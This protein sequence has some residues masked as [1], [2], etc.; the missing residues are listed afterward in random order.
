[1]MRR[2]FTIVELVIVLTIMG[3]L[4]AVAVVNINASQI[5][6]RDTERKADIEAISMAL[7][8]YYGN[9]DSASSGI[10]DMSG[11]SYPSTASLSSDAAF[12]TAFPDIDQKSVRAPD[13]ELTSPRS[14]VPATNSTASTS[15]VLPQPTINSYVYQP[16]KKDGSLC[17]QILQK[18]D[19]R[20]FNL[21]YRLEI[22]NSVQMVTSRHQS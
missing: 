13:V 3:I 17:T 18:G 16:I 14:I 1:M 20:R 7:E 6:A 15:G 4:L 2:G 9:E 10:Y 22:D 8:A 19:C 21:Y 12:Q 5:N 11:D